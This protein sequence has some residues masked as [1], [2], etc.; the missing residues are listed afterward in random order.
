LPE[1]WVEY[2]RTPS[3]AQK[4]WGNGGY[5]AQFWLNASSDPGKIKPRRSDVP[6]DAFWC[7]GHE[8][9]SVAIVPSRNLVVVRLGMTH[10]PLGATW[11]EDEFLAEVLKHLPE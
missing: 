11:D 7:L 6:D 5:G 9:Q 1:G 2:T 4:T 3:T 10:H 8:G